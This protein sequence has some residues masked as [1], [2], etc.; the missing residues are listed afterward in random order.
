[1]MVQYIEIISPSKAKKKTDIVLTCNINC[2]GASMYQTSKFSL[3]PI[4]LLIN[5]LPFKIRF[6]MASLVAALLTTVEPNVDLMKLFMDSF[7]LQFKPLIEKGL[8]ITNKK[9][10]RFIQRFFYTTVFRP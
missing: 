3:W 7:L 10:R 5:E 4:L 1:M 6:K 8:N 2:D 9:N